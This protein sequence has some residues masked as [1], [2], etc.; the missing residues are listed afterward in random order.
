MPL[1]QK[2]PIL[3]ERSLNQTSSDY[4][5]KNDGWVIRFKARLHG[6]I[7][8]QWYEL[9]SMLNNVILNEEENDV[10]L[11]KWSANKKFLVKS[12]YNHLI[13]YAP[14]PYSRIWKAKIL[15]KIKIFMWLVEQKA[16]LT[17]DNM[18]KRW[19]GDPSCYFSFF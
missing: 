8:D 19:Q 3:Y 4:Q 14:G 16:I 13:G 15:K 17:K 7:R 1:C 6:C 9:S 5:V 12:V 2:Y 10:V 11:W 18:V